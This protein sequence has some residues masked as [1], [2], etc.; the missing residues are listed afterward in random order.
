[1]DPTPAILRARARWIYRGDRRPSFA[2][3]T[4]PGEESVWDFP[5]PPVI[6][7]VGARLEVLTADSIV[8]ATERGVRVLE[9][10]GAPTY[11]FPP[12]DVRCDVLVPLPGRSLCE[13]KGRAV[14]FG[15]GTV[16]PAGWSYEDTFPEFVALEGWF[17]FYPAR[18]ACSVGG[19]RVQ[20]QP[21]GYYGGWVTS[22]LKGPIKGAPG[23]EGW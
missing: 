13:W 16:A 4:V 20:S 2:E 15:L 22:R 23:T 9:T 17:A 19:E 18:L 1:M 12:E 14:S 7:P 8:A 3:E 5:R 21:G 11:Y 10:A 6:E